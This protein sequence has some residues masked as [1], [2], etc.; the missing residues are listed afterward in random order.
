MEIIIGKQRQQGKLVDGEIIIGRQ[1][2]Q[3]KLVV[4]KS[5]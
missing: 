3:G 2:Q 5:S 1:M 4:G